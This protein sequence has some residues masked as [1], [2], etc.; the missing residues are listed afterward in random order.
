MVKCSKCGFESKTKTKFCSKCGNPLINTCS[1]CGYEIAD[2][3]NFCPKCGQKTQPQRYCSKCGSELPEDS[4]FCTK[5]GFQHGKI[6]KKS[7]FNINEF[8]T[9]YL[10]AVI[11]SI[12]LSLLLIYIMDFISGY[13]VPYYP[14]AFYTALTI[15]VIIFAPRQETPLNGMIYGVL[16]GLTIGLLEGFIASIP[17]GSYYTY[18]FGNRPLLL[19]FWGLTVGYI[20]NYLL[21]EYFDDNF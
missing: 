14:F 20:S 19:I 7:D 13:T 21:K 11:I 17:L 5:C 10:I 12:A 6:E 3:L 16:V 2:N 18:Y 1:N 4:L 8:L 15:A 9:H